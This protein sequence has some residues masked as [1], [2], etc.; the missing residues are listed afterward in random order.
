MM[1]FRLIKASLTKLLGDKSDGKYRVAG[2]QKRAQA[3]SEI[4]KFD[5]IVQVYYS[6]GQFPKSGGGPS[7]PV[8]HDMTINVDM[9]VSMRAQGDLLAIDNPASSAAQLQKAISE[10]KSAEDLVDDA[11]DELSELVFQVVMDARHLWLG[12]DKPVGSR[13]VPSINKDDP[14]RYGELV[15]LTGAMPVTCNKDEQVQGVTPQPFNVIET[16]VIP[17]DD[18]VGKAGT[19]VGFGDFY[20]QRGT[21][22]NYVQRDTGDHYVTRSET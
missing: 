16:E 13:W 10:L 18:A 8:K 17:N 20:I 9:F 19:I 15:T 11:F 2:Y 3:M 22:D 7:G 21:L 12:H 14:V 6:A 4:A 5:R 1:N